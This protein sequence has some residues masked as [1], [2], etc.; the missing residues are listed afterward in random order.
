MIIVGLSGMGLLAI[1]LIQ[2]KRK[3]LHLWQVF[4]CVVLGVYAILI[5]DSIFTLMNVGLTLINLVQY[6]KE[7]QR[8]K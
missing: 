2:K 1:S 8:S 5:G 6:V 4:A 3:Y 7:K